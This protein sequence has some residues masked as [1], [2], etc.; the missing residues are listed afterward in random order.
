MF[1]MKCSVLPNVSSFQ[2]GG[3]LTKDLALSAVLSSAASVAY[4]DCN[5]VVWRQRLHP[6]FDAPNVCHHPY[7][8]CSRSGRDWSFFWI[9]R[10]KRG[11]TKTSTSTIGDL[12][13]W[14]IGIG[15]SGI[16]GT[17]TTIT[18]F[19]MHPR[20]RVISSLVNGWLVLEK[21]RSLRLQIYASVSLRLKFF[22]VV[23]VF[24]FQVGETLFWSNAF[25][26]M[27]TAMPLWENDEVALFNGWGHISYSGCRFL[28][29]YSLSGSFFAV[30]FSWLTNV[31][32]ILGHLLPLKHACLSSPLNRFKPNFR[33]WFACFYGC[34]SFNF[35]PKYPLSLSRSVFGLFCFWS[36]SRRFSA[37]CVIILVT[38]FIMKQLA[39]YL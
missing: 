14:L 39:T 3:A 26:V 17:Q 12:A 10:T 9:C 11:A 36:I 21:V 15:M 30:V 23:W 38:E 31:F 33:R 6:A 28:C 1:C 7:I 32:R 35:T 5:S 13:W 2:E 24:E 18:L 16:L 25:S 27:F 34:G 37:L 20:M 22:E 29:S 8:Q 4:P 19:L